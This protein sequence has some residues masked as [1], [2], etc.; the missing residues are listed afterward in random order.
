MGGFIR[1][2]T[3]RSTAC[4]LNKSG[5]RVCMMIVEKEIAGNVLLLHLQGRCPDA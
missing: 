3:E 5:M 4:Y 2:V 1:E